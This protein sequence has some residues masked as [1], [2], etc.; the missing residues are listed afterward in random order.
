MMV[1]E[2]HGHLEG[3]RLVMVSRYIMNT[4]VVDA[5]AWEEVK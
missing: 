5:E 4:Q 1:T 3:Y 2:H